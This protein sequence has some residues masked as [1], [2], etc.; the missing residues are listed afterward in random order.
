MDR[1]NELTK[2]QAELDKLLIAKIDDKI[3]FCK[4][5]RR[6]VST[7]F[8]DPAEQFTLN[9]YLLKNKDINYI[10]TG[11]YEDAERKI[12][13]IE[14]KD[15][16]WS[17]IEK[18]KDNTLKVIRI[19]LPKELWGTFEHKT[20]LGALMKLGLERRKIGDILVKGNGADI[21]IKDDIED[22]L[23]KEL[24]N[25]TRFQK[26]KIEAKEI[27]DLEVI[28]PD[29]KQFTINVPS[30]RL[31]AVVGELARCSRSDAS[32][33]LTDERVFVD[34]KLEIRGTKEIKENQFITIRGKGRFKILKINQTRKGRF[35][36]E[37]EK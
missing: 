5:R 20:Y 8:L 26:S 36:V 16:E 27:K 6:L 33:Y 17:N 4:T 2:E 10:F 31:D 3:K 37:V 28:I 13:S 24:S 19:I 21:I 35:Q 11:G 7:D 34:F 15:I 14:P 22:F 12:L 9:N 18:E 23:L 25:L 1:L 32:R 29:K 30:M